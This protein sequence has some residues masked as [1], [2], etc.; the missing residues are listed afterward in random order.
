MRKS[1][2]SNY[3]SAIVEYGQAKAV[4]NAI[5]QTAIDMNKTF[6]RTLQH[7]DKCCPQYL[8]LATYNYVQAINS[9]LLGI[10]DSTDNSTTINYYSNLGNSYKS[11]VF[12][13]LNS[14]G[15]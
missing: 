11:E 3:T 2:N 9:A 5:N 13:F 4:Y 14:N 12:N 15:N 7:I 1:Y 6:N 8:A 10:A